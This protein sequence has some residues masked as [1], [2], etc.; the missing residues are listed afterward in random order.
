NPTGHGITVDDPVIIPASRRLLP[1]TSK[2]YQAIRH[3]AGHEGGRV[4]LLRE[5]DSTKN[6]VT[7]TSIGSLLLRTAKLQ[8]ARVDPVIR[9]RNNLVVP[10]SARLRRRDTNVGDLGLDVLNVQPYRVSP[11]ALNDLFHLVVIQRGVFRRF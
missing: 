11:D 6:H 1:Q 9:R 4:G 8:V 7:T 3:A 2:G 5:N 10:E